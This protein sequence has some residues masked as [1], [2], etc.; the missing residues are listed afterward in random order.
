MAVLII[1]LLIVTNCH[2]KELMAVLIKMALI[3]MAVLINPDYGINTLG[4]KY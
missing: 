2:T 3:K 1:P 4:K